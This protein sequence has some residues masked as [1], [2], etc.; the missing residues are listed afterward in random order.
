LARL[1]AAEGSPVVKKQMEEQAAA[2]HKLAAKRAK[3]TE[4][5]ASARRPFAG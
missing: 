4:R 2:Y 5:A 3:Q 1:A